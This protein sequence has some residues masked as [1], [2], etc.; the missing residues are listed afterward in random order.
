MKYVPLIVIAVL[1]LGV[2]GYFFL[3]QQD[4]ITPQGVS[5]VVPS[6][7]SKGMF[8]SIK[9]ALSKSLSL[10]CTYTD[11]KGT[12]SKTYIKAGA[13]R[14]E[15]SAK[16]D[17]ETQTYMIMKDKKIYSWNPITK[18]GTLIEL[19]SFDITPK[20]IPTGA[21]KEESVQKDDEKESILA[22]IEKYKDAC[23]PAT[24]ADSLFVPPTDVTFQD[25]SKMMKQALPSG[26]NLEELQ[27]Q[28]APQ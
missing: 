2:G 23:K 5:T 18:E 19:T 1:V 15:V 26:F 12:T 10:E 13:V 25:F 7:E 8:T 21:M 27:K 16:G 11:E 3:S 22:Q 17:T 24:V 28:F 4:K 20:V 9:D 6:E 14:T